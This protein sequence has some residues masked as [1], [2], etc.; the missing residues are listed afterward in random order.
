MIEKD[1]SEIKFLEEKAKEVRRSIVTLFGKVGGGHFG[2]SLSAVEVVVALYYGILHIRPHEPNWPDRDRFI[3]S[4]GHACPALY[5]VLADKGYFPKDVF[6]NFEELDNPLTMH[7]D[8]RKVPGIDMSTGSMGH[9][10][11]VGVGM[12]LAGQ[13]DK[14]DYRVFVL[15]GDGETQ[16]GSV[17]EAVM[18]ASHFKLDNLIAIVD[19]NYLSVDGFVEEIISIEPIV[20]RWKNFGWQVT[21]IDGHN[22]S[23]VVNALEQARIT[24]NGHKCPKVIIAR[25]VKGKGVSFMENKR[26]CHRIDITPEQVKLALSELK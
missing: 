9:G 5:T 8:M 25:T 21:E 1:V 18:A 26:E 20:E 19:R 11:S 15:M 17:W 12:A 7:P 14:K 10:L 2:G 3:L 6:N 23:E 16:E 24:G 22:M 4:K 13:L